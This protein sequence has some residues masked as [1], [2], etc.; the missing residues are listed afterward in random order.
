MRI[1]DWSSD[2][3]SSDLD[4][5]TLWNAVEAAEK[6]KDAQLAREVEFA[7]PRELSKKD[8]IK[9]A[10]EFVKA[11][12]VEKG[13]IADL[14]VHWDIGKDGR[15]KPHAHVMLTMREVTKDGFGEIGRASCRE[16]VCQSV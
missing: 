16:R 1:I 6:R 2:V 13:M 3:C 4:R 8:N 5:A 11:E 9:L 10:R 12:L 15:A 14:N 7:L